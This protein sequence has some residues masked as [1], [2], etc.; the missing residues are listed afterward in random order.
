[1]KKNFNL[2][3]SDEPFKSST[4]M[5]KTVNCVYDGPR[6]II[7]RVNNTTKKVENSV[8][9]FVNV[10]DIDLSYFTEEGYSF[11]VIDAN[12]NPF[13][14]AYL[15]Q[16]YSYGE[17]DN[18]VETLPTGE[19]WEFLYDN[20]GGIIG[21]IYNNFDLVYDESSKTFKEP[22]R[23]THPITRESFF[24]SLK[25]FPE[26]LTNALSSDEY[27]DEERTKLENY[28]TWIEN[29]STT[30]ADVDHWKIPFPVN[31]PNF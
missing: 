8:G 26:R 22:S 23:V 11:I 25:N 19:S 17:V 13:E 5:N 10:E 27:S 12:V 6:Y 1:M 3:L 29:L 2:I 16:N 15:T 4:T 14:A 21:Q 9:S 24:D 7:G 30:Y 31:I 28:K 20:Y 18:Y